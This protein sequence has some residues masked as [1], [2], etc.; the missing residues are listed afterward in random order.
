[1]RCGCIKY[2]IGTI[3]CLF[4]KNGVISCYDREPILNFNET[5]EK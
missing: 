1:M 2:F 3:F 5:G 4:F